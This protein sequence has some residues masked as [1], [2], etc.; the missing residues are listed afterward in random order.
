MEIHRKK[1][2]EVYCLISEK[3]VGTVTMLHVG[4]SGVRTRAEDRDFPFLHRAQTGTKAHPY[5][6]Q[7][8]TEVLTRE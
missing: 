3:S 7:N 2:T 1:Q 6:I 4:R 8:V 5:S